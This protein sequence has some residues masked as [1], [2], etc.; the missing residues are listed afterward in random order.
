MSSKASCHPV[1]PGDV[2]ADPVG[3]QGGVVES[4]AHE[5]TRDAE[6]LGPEVGGHRR[7]GVVD[8]R[9]GPMREVG[10]VGSLDR[11]A[12]G[13]ILID[14]GQLLAPQRDLVELV[15]PLRRRGKGERRALRGSARRCAADGWLQLMSPTVP[16]VHVAPYQGVGDGALSPPDLPL[17][18]N[19]PD[20][21]STAPSATDHLDVLIVG[22]GVSG[23]GAAYHLQATHPAKRYAILEARDDL[24]GT[25][26][27]FRYPGHPLG[28]RSAHLRLRVQALDRG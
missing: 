6:R 8:V 18:G 17:T 11:R 24:G 14:A 4:A 3:V 20:M 19:N 2:L 23:I 27:L 1:A 5:V 28:L 21:P 25:W 26:D 15:E 22:A 9:L 7:S 12:Q 16:E 10:P 13:G